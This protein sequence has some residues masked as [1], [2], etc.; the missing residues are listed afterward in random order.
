MVPANELH[1]AKMQ[2]LSIHVGSVKE[3]PVCSLLALL[4][5]L[6]YKLGT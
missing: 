1:L 4:C 2:L 6:H 3:T 5:S